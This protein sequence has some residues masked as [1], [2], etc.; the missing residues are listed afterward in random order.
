M[1]YPVVARPDYQVMV[2][3]ARAGV[4]WKGTLQGDGQVLAEQALQLKVHSG[5]CDQTIATDALV[6]WAG[7]DVV[8]EGGVITFQQ[9]LSYVCCAELA[10]FAGREGANIRII[11]TNTGEVCR[12]MCGYLIAGEVLGL[13]PGTYTVSVWGVQH[14]EAHDLELLGS[15]V[16]TI[17]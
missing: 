13:E 14:R 10:L 12:C 16:V 17:T 9:R 5:P 7:V 15:A 6:K 11:E 3:H 2:S 1:G 8:A 4:V